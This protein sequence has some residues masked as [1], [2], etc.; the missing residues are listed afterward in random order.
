MDYA[1]SICHMTYSN[2]TIHEREYVRVHKINI[3][4][5]LAVL[6]VMTVEAVAENLNDALVAYS[7]G[8]YVTA[9]KLLKPMA[10][11]G[12]AKA[13]YNLG[14]LYLKGKGVPQ[15]DKE[16]AILFRRAADKGNTDAQCNLGALYLS[17]KGVE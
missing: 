6:A 1:V 12:D 4:L 7:K 16:A 11:N 9:A 3:L 17:G 14:V 8:D 2:R 13:Q 10:A 15:N 5:V